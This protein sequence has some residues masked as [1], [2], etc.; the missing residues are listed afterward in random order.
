V[1]TWRRL[2]W[3][4]LALLLSGLCWLTRELRLRAFSQHRSGQR[5]EDLYYLPAHAWLPVLS[6]GYRQAAADLIW[7]RSLV[8]FGEDIGQKGQVKHVFEYTDAILA[9]DP[10]FRPAYRWISTAAIYR[11]VAISVDQGL[12][13][14][15]YLKR[16]LA[17]WP[18]DWELHWDYGSL[19]RFELA[20]LERD[21][22]RKRVLL[23]RAAPHISA[24]A[25]HGAG[26]S[27]LAL[28]SVELLN[29][30]GHVEQA[31]HHLEE[32]AHTVQDEEVKRE[33]EQKLAQLRSQAAYEAVRTAEQQF[34]DQRL[35][36]FPYLSP[37]LFLFVGEQRDTD[38]YAR[39]LSS[40]F[41]SESELRQTEA[42]PEGA[43]P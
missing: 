12:R 43:A 10:D 29:K 1:Q 31:I 11:P 19:L 24:A 26:P 2:R 3:L 37:G 9:L 22:V 8:Y 7:C 18:N 33:V 20:P 16:A 39:Y 6:L 41:L 32:L 42:A 13:A 28:N 15:E 5:Y 4:A 27:W 40:G 17:R 23:E 34:E 25:L 14:A 36:S 30:L 21:P 35:R 38:E